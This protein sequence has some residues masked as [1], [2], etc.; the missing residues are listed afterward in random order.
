MVMVHS[1][2]RLSLWA[3]SQQDGKMFREARSVARPQRDI[4]RRPP[5]S[6]T[7]HDPG[8][9]GRAFDLILRGVAEPF[10]QVFQNRNV[11]AA[12]GTSAFFPLGG[13]GALAPRTPEPRDET[14]ST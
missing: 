7:E 5:L 10:R 3:T 9:A 1:C 2:S 8:R 6:V 13:P 4:A 12:G 14:V 11:L